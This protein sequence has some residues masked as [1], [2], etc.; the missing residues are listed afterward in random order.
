MNEALFGK[1]DAHEATLA[2]PGQAEGSLTVFA[3]RGTDLLSGVASYVVTVVSD[4]TVSCTPA[5]RTSRRSR[6]PAR[7][8]STRSAGPSLDSREAASFSKTT[9]AT[10]W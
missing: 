7:P 4:A 10:T 8:A 5:H 1:V 6:S 2:I 3:I 9:P